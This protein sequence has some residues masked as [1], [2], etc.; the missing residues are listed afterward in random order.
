M[1]DINTLMQAVLQFRDERNWERFHTSK[2]CA[3][4]LMVEA[5][6]AAELFLYKTDEEIEKAGEKWKE[7]LGDELSDVMYW[8]L[9]TAHKY[10]IDLSKAVMAKLEKTAKRYPVALN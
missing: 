4:G 8:L 5:S 1:S 9:I 6:E 10:D 2:D 3:I 7:D